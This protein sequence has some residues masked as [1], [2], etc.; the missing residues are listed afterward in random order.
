MK[1]LSRSVVCLDAAKSKFAVL[2]VLS[3]QIQL[4]SL[5]HLSSNHQPQDLNNHSRN[6]THDS[7]QFGILPPLPFFA[8]VFISS[9]TAWV[10][11]GQELIFGIK[12]VI[13]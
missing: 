1:K 9:C 4:G 7:G 3:C 8:N 10:H 11:F 5:E 6:Q 2:I 13:W 12:Q